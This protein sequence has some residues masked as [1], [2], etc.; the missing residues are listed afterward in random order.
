MIKVSSSIDKHRKETGKSDLFFS[1]DSQYEQRCWMYTI[2]FLKTKAIT[3]AYA[4]N[5][6][7]M[8]TFLH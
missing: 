6:P 7:I 4:K 1:C 5:N 8:Y 3:D 2:D